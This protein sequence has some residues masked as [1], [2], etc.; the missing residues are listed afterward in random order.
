M[1]MLAPMFLALILVLSLL[2]NTGDS[3]YAQLQVR[4]HEEIKQYRSFV[5]VA[6][7]FFSI[8]EDA[9]ALKA[10]YWSDLRHAGPPGMRQ[11]LMS[12]AWYAIK[13]ET[14]TWAAC[15]DL[16]E[17]SLASISALFPHVESSLQLRKIDDMHVVGD[18]VTA[19]D[20]A[21]LC[22]LGG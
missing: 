3:G 12:P 22:A 19:N 10:Y 6:Q 20:A 16:R 1:W 2:G 13:S 4:T 5:A 8:E 17:E 14:G 15:T 18:E 11:S 7:A 9:H 21:A